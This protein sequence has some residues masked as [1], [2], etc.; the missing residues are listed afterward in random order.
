MIRLGIRLTLNGGREAL[1]RLVIL[2]VSIGLGAGL[3]LIAVSGTNAVNH[4]NDRYAWLESTAYA[5]GQAAPEWWLV[6]ADYYQGQVIGRVDVA[7]TRRCVRRYRRS[8]AACPGVIG[9][10]PHR[11]WPRCC[12]PSRPPSSPT[13]SPASWPA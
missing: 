11:P 2:V 7:G 5:K 10:T 1:V 4:Q 12:A 6:T 9:T 8:L 3:L 13:G